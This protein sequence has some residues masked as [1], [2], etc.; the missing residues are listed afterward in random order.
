LLMVLLIVLLIILLVVGW[1]FRLRDA[2]SPYA[3]TVSSFFLSRSLFL[4]SSLFRLLFCWFTYNECF[5]ATICRG[6]HF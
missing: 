2:V 4:F 6:S 1:L 5:F 3:F